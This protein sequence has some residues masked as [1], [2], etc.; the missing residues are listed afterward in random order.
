MEQ[1]FEMAGVA[2]SHAIWSV[3]DGETLIPILAKL[4]ENGDTTMQ[5]MMVETEE[6]LAQAEQARMKAELDKATSDQQLKDALATIE[7]LK[8]GKY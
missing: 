2:M 5:R 4:G 6:A 7:R 3:Q 1:V 8:S